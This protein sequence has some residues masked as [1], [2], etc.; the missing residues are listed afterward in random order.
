MSNPENVQHS[1]ASRPATRSG[2]ER[3]T[4]GS[5]IPNRQKVHDGTVAN[6]A[7][8]KRTWHSLLVPV[9]SSFSADPMNTAP[10][11]VLSDYSRQLEMIERNRAQKNLAHRMQNEKFSSDDLA[12]NSSGVTRPLRDRLDAVPDEVHE[13]VGHVYDDVVELLRN[14]PREKAAALLK[15]VADGADLATL[16]SQYKQGDLQ[17]QLSLTPNTIRR[18]EFPFVSEMPRHLYI[19]E[20][21]YIRSLLMSA[22]VSHPMASE[23]KASWQQLGP[24][25]HAPRASRV[26]GPDL[27]R[28]SEQHISYSVPYHTARVVGP[29]LSKLTAAPWT[30]VISDNRL[31]QQL[32]SCYFQFSNTSAP[33]VHIDLFLDDMVAGRERFCSPLLVN[34]ILASGCVSLPQHPRLSNLL[35]TL[36]HVAKLS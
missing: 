2:K 24:P 22:I 15:R 3:A 33:K 8:K 29:R 36:I 18:Y 9:D 16:V 10:Q 1:L 27:L 6:S 7:P 31:L 26:D 5:T 13:E 11:S 23:E 19:T 17:M 4:V 12:T 25:R 21:P 30:Q 32:I 35:V 28:G 14:A 34:A 20:N